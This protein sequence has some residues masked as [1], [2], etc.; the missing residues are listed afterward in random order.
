MRGKR[1]KTI[2][3]A[4]HNSERI[5]CWGLPDVR[6]Y[7]GVLVALCFSCLPTICRPVLTQLPTQSSCESTNHE[8]TERLRKIGARRLSPQVEEFEL[9][10]GVLLNLTYEDGTLAA[11]KVFLTSNYTDRVKAFHNA[12]RRGPDCK[13]CMSRPT[14]ERLLNQVAQL[15]PLGGF[16]QANPIGV[17]AQT[18]WV[19]KTDEY[20]CAEVIRQERKCDETTSNI[21][22]GIIDFKVFYW[23]ALNGRIEAKH[24][25][26]LGAS[27]ALE[28]PAYYI[29]VAGK[30]VQVSKYDYD[31]LSEG[32]VVQ[33]QRTLLDNPVRVVSVRAASKQSKIIT[34][35]GA[36]DVTQNYTYV[37]PIVIQGMV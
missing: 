31:R 25:R 34:G 22:C 19:F 32:Q 3:A 15:R 36:M 16:T 9:K 4:D 11:A 13:V 24:L 12:K 27:P 17:V 37:V 6:L 5:L 2:M 10:K 8:M 28:F 1:V 7:F 35:N 29:V 26:T 21:G 30:E 20:E 23:L 18:G 33:L 14:Y